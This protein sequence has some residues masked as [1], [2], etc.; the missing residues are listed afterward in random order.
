[1]RA[2]I[3][4]GVLFVHTKPM[5]LWMQSIMS[6]QALRVCL[7]VCMFVCSSSGIG[8]MDCD[9]CFH[10]AQS[11]PRQWIKAQVKQ[12]C[13]PNDGWNFLCRFYCYRC[14]EQVEWC[15]LC[16]NFSCILEFQDLADKE[17]EQLEEERRR[18]ARAARGLPPPPLEL[19]QAPP[20]PQLP[21]HL[22]PAFSLTQ[23]NL[24][25]QPA[26][27]PPP[28]PQALIDHRRPPPQQPKKDIVCRYLV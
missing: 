24:Q 13:G 28:Q 4:S 11:Q 27:P 16:D 26:K 7:L 25:S 17:E 9:T 22:Q 19:P 20:L 12:V 14:F 2:F 8:A 23:R 5:S 6:L 10:C 1:M 15:Y 21:A 18:V 3:R